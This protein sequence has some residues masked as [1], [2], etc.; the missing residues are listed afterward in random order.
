MSN[1]EFILLL[2]FGTALLGGILAVAHISAYRLN[3]RRQLHLHKQVLAP[4]PG[5]ILEPELD[6]GP[7]GRF[8]DVLVGK[9]ISVQVRHAETAR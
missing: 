1:N 5:S 6:L 7:D 2:S 8:G 4:D 3:Q 9:N